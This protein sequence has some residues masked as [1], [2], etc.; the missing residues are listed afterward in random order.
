MS[1]GDDIKVALA[2]KEAAD[3]WRANHDAVLSE[4][5]AKGHGAGD[6][7]WDATLT[8]LDEGAG[9]I[10]WNHTAGRVFE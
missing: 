10:L 7:E 8:E 5:E 1:V 6:Y 4:L 3:D 2:L 9:E